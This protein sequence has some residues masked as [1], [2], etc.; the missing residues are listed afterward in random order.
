MAPDQKK[1]QGTGI[2]GVRPEIDIEVSLGRHA[3]VFQA[4]V[5][6]IIYCLLENIKRYYCNKRIFMISDSQAALKAL[7]S[8]LTK[9][10]LVWNCFQLLLE[11]AEQ[12][13]VKLIW[14]PGHMGV[15]G[16]EKADQLAKLGADEPLLGPEPFC[17]ITKETAR[18]S[19]DLRAQS[20]A[21]MA[22][23]Y[24]SGQRHAQKMIN[25]SS[26]NLTSGL[27][28]LSRNQM[29]LV[30]GLLTVHGL[31]IHKEEPVC[32]K[33][34]M[35]KETAHHILFECEALGRIRYSVLGPSGFELETIHQEPTK[36]LLDLIRKAGIFYGIY[37]LPWG[38]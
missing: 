1:A 30:A 14:V 15:E 28:I 16:N 8:F 11:L 7:N 6:A 29:R 24:T 25:K 21:R 35:G 4:E 26:N 23:K 37:A 19:I 13:E 33:F 10:K 20:K 5:Y 31:G 36:S 18:R 3:T 32:R 2:H 38:A 22:W 34:G 17:G 27:L 9:Y 12:N